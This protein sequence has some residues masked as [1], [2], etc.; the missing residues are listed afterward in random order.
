MTADDIHLRREIASLGQRII[1]LKAQLAAAVEAERQACEDI[2]REV[3]AAI[4]F[5]DG[6]TATAHKI[7][8]AIAARKP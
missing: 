8:N 5:S 3:E 4:D 2:A 6:A 1:E 7:I